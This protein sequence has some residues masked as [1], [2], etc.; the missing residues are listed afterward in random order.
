MT[1]SFK[2]RKKKIHCMLYL[3]QQQKVKA[4]YEFT[5]ERRCKCSWIIHYRF[6]LSFSFSLLDTFLFLIG[7]SIIL[8][9][10]YLCFVVE[11]TWKWIKN[12]WGIFSIC[13]LLQKDLHAIKK[14]RL[15]SI[16]NNTKHMDWTKT[17]IFLLRAL[18]M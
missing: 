10:F 17:Y 5:Y 2:T 15:S 16:F 3:E 6:S 1:I 7:C 13:D 14:K 12:F 9:A 11:I 4:A 8:Q 18:S